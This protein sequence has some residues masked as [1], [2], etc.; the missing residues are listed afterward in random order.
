MYFEGLECV[1]PV[2]VG[3]HRNK[4]EVR[5]S[6]YGDARPKKVYIETRLG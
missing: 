2:P 6:I 1:C 5:I 4:C 3:F